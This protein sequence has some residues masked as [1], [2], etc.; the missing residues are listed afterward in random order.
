MTVTEPT[1]RRSLTLPLLVLYGLGTTI[2]AGIYALIGKAAGRAGLYLPF[3]FLVAL[4]LA[5]FTAFSFAELA[6]RLPRAAGAALYVREGLRS[7][8]LS[9]AVGAMV[10]AAASI[11]AAAIANG[12]AGYLGVFVAAPRPLLVILFVLVLALIATWGIAESVAAASLV[13]VLEIG[14]LCLVIAG[15]AAG[16]AGSETRLVDLVPPLDTTV[17]AGVFAGAVLAFYAFIGFEDMV[18]VAEEVKDVTRTLPLAIVITLAATTL[19]YFVLAVVAVL[20]VPPAEL[21]A[22]EAPLALVF[23]RGSGLSGE[24]VGAVAVLAVLNGALIQII[25]ASRMLYGLAEQGLVAAAF[26]RIHRRTRT[27]HLATAAVSAGVLALALAFPIETLAET[28]SLVMLTIF[29]FVNLAL[30]ALK[31]RRPPPAGVFAVPLWVP[32]AGA[33]VSAGFAGAELARLIGG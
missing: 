23:A 21:A 22:A 9:L 26:G 7:D 6:A 29:A 12:A 33:T 19:L 20:A 5:S 27:P 10:I 28:T 17:W 16:I 24:F 30:L 2:G 1:L 4:A 11:S 15:G 32:A 13:T 25:M 18:N 3:S 31:R 8:R 14:G